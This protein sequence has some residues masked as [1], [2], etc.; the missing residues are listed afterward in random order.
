[1]RRREAG[2]QELPRRRLVL[3]QREKKEGRGLHEIK[4]GNGII[5]SQNNA[6]LGL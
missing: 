4:R 2:W 5:Y 6:K 1:M 3:L